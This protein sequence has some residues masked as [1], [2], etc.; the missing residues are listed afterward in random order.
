MHKISDERSF[1][2]RRWSE[3]TRARPAE[4]DKRVPS[5]LVLE[6]LSGDNGIFL[7]YIR[8]ESKAKVRSWMSRPGAPAA[9]QLI[10]E[11]HAW[12]FCQHACS[13]FSKAFFRQRVPT[14]DGLRALRQ[15]IFVPSGGRGGRPCLQITGE[16]DQVRSRSGS[17]R[18]FL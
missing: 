11:R 18:V 14:W 5:N 8:D 16:A 9:K 7:D 4:V 2:D 12:S 3:W 1:R 10:S 6:I 17:V 13:C 15:V